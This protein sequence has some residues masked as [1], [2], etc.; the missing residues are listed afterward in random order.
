MIYIQ[1]V[2]PALS[3]GNHSHFCG[4]ISGWICWVQPVHCQNSLGPVPVH[5]PSSPNKTI[6][7]PGREKAGT[8]QHHCRNH[9]A[10][11]HLPV[12]EGCVV[13]VAARWKPPNLW[14]TDACWLRVCKWA[15]VH[16]RGQS[17]YG[18]NAFWNGDKTALK[19]E[20][21]CAGPWL[22]CYWHGWRLEA[23]AGTEVE[24]VMVGG[25]DGWEELCTG[26]QTWKNS[27]LEGH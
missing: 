4:V 27:D 14:V 5:S 22:G 15:C 13:F 6:A 10:P 25:G 2:L 1:P 3:R 20:G 26:W 18:E 12:C 11:F 19:E 17:I 8:I 16:K 23:A 21:R 7:P 24:C 9:P